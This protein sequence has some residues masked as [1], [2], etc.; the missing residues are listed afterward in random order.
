MTPIETIVNL[1]I[2]RK[3]DFS[4]Q[5]ETCMVLLTVE[6]KL[7]LALDCILLKILDDARG[8]GMP[9]T[10][11]LKGNLL[12]IETGGQHIRIQFIKGIPSNLQ[13]IEL[14]KG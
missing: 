2:E 6:K 13:K 3:A 14:S 10:Y 4:V 12:N 11:T 1:L 7:D 8:K 9:A 5:H